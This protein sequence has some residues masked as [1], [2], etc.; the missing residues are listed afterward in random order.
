MIHIVCVKSLVHVGLRVYV[1]SLGH[2]I[3]LLLFSFIWF[4]FCIMHQVV[5]PFFIFHFDSMHLW[6]TF[7]SN[8]DLLFLLCLW[9][10][11]T[12]FSWHCLKCFCIHCERCE[13]SCFAWTNSCL[14]T[15]FLSN[16]LFCQWI[17]IVLFV[18]DTHILINVVI[19]DCIQID[20]VSCVV[21]SHKVVTTLVVQAKEWFYHDRQ[22]RNAIFSLAIETFG[23]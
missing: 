15:T 16:F 13:V 5:L 17:D 21:S 11:I 14:L 20:L 23:W 10:R 19:V 1:S 2:S 3:F 7:I 8:G 4:F 12:C 9:W 22:S 6:S 18:D